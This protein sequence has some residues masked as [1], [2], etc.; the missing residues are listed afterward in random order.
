MYTPNDLEICVGKQNTSENMMKGNDKV[1][2]ETQSLLNSEE[3][4]AIKAFRLELVKESLLPARFDH[5]YMM[6][7]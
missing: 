7:R 5:Q 4:K 2:F 3:L 6:L 1:S